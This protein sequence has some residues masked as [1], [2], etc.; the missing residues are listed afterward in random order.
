M[1]GKRLDVL[2][3]PDAIESLGSANSGITV[4]A[5]LGR[6]LF[7]ASL[8]FPERRAKYRRGLSL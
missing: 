5:R 1:V 8:A 7:P 6:G 2:F 3:A 4:F